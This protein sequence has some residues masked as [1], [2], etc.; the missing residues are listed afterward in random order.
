[1]NIGH[2]AAAG[3]MWTIGLGLASRLVGLVGT[4]IITHYLSPAVMG[5]VAAA[6]VL[7][8]TANWMTAWGFNQ[9]V[10]VRG[11]EGPAA[12]FHATVLHLALGFTA[13]LV[14]LLAGSGLSGFLNAPNLGLFLPGM[15]LVVAI[16]RLS[17]IPNKLLMRQM[18]FRTVAIAASTGE[19]VYVSL[20][21][22]LVVNTDLGGLAIVAA[23]IVQATVVSTIEI[24]ALGLRTWLTPVP[25]SWKRA[26]DI[27]RFGA[28][29]GLESLLSE[30]SRQ[31]DKLAFS[32]LFGPQATGMYS[33]AYN[34]ADLPASYVGEHVAAVLLP[35]LVHSDASSR[36]RMFCRAFGL[37][38]LVTLPIAIGLAAVAHTLVELL[39]PSEWQPVAGFLVVLA[40]AGVFRPI[41]SIAGSLLMAS[42][43]NFLLF[44]AEF[45]KVTALLFSMW[46]LAPFG[47]VASAA[48]VALAMGLQAALLILVLGRSGFPVR[49]LLLQARGPVVAA[50]TLVAAV[51]LV[52][53]T[54]GRVPATPVAAQLAA[55]ILVGA[56][57]YCLGAW[58]FARQAVKEL[59]VMITTQIFRSRTAVT[60]G[61]VASS[62]SNTD[63][64]ASKP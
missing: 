9:Y 15:V 7:A 47:Q 11:A 10:I 27:L 4:V 36:P 16:R 1:M 23:N 46:V 24:S 5:E 55:E 13:L 58:F 12:V 14:V 34:L 18:R 8:F 51:V 22:L 42:E 39:L 33:L 21:V 41:N 61:I 53:S 3:A 40:A 45:C 52:R 57:A 44:A 2:Q 62:Q 17:S 6:T 63:G 20:A 48:S 32:R 31:W 35:T 37:L 28:P 54:L 50:I 64:Q 25:W 26:R 49:D 43:R 30:A 59:I 60:T 29:L 38:L 56:G 19:V